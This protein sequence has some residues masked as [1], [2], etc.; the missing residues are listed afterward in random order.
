MGFAF[1]GQ[2][3]LLLLPLFVFVCSSASVIA[4]CLE[5]LLLICC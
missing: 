3:L 5:L 4:V 2:F 1:V